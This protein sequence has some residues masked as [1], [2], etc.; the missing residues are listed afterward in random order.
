MLSFAKVKERLASKDYERVISGAAST[1]VEGTSA[2][3]F[4]VEALELESIQ[5]VVP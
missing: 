1:Q 5:S 2:N 3:T 4:M